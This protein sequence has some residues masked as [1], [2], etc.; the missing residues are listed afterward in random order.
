MSD[1]YPE[2]ILQATVEK[3]VAKVKGSTLTLSLLGFLGGMYISLGYLAYIRVVGGMPHDWGSLAVFIGA[4]VFPIGLVCI[5]IGGGELIT[6][7]MM[8]VLVA[9]L[10]KRISLAQWGRNWLIVTLANL[11]GAFFVAWFFGHYVGLTEGAVLEKTISVAEGKVAADFGRALVS[12][13]GCNWMV[14]MGVWL[15]YGA[16]SFS[17]KILGIWFPV[18][19]FVLVGFQHVVANMFVI[20][21]AIWAG[22][23][24]SWAQFGWNMVSVYLGNAIGGAV[25]VGAVYFY[26]YR[27]K[28]GLKA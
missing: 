20:P 11:V 10:A 5:L 9:W 15:C 3:G 25:F 17:G 14:C 21:A 27:G 7:N 12:G 22:A 19:I 23:D 13:I 4:A 24:I 26:A 2:Q 16:H 6:G 28:L 8:V 18:M 1:L